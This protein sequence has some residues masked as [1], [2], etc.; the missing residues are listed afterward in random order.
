MVYPR[1]RNFKTNFPILR[2]QS[3]LILENHFNMFRH[4]YSFT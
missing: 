3:F 4:K 1:I 2:A